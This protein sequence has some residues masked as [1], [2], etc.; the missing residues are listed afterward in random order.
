[1][2]ENSHCQCYKSREFSWNFELRYNT[3]DHSIFQM[4]KST[5][6]PKVAQAVDGITM[7]QSLV[8]TVIITQLSTLTDDMCAQ[9]P[10]LCSLCCT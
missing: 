4:M 7:A 1:M 6:L 9:K 10:I 5:I 8:L 2:Y 3:E